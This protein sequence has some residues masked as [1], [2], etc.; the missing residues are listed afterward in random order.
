MADENK[1][2]L[3]E[4]KKLRTENC[5]LKEELEK[6]LSSSESCTCGS[7]RS[8]VVPTPIRSAE[9]INVSQQ[10]LQAV[11]MALFLTVQ[12]CFWAWTVTGVLCLMPIAYHYSTHSKQN[13][14][15]HSADK[16]NR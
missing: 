10:K 14:S 7:V 15:V 1:L 2:L 8:T 9:S 3:G 12:A 11:R 5:E 6:R 4:I 16:L 13:C